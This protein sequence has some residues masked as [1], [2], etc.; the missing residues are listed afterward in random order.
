VSLAVAAGAS[1]AVGDPFAEAVDSVVA[2]AILGRKPARS[3]SGASMNTAA[4]RKSAGSAT[5]RATA[6][7][8]PTN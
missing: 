4:L 2:T 1:T 7:S 8:A 5:R 3:A 6:S